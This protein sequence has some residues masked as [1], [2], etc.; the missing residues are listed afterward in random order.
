MNQAAL[1]KRTRRQSTRRALR[2][3]GR[4]YELY[5]FLLPALIYYIVFH[6]WPMYGVQ[7][8]FKDFI[9]IKGIEGSPWVGLK[10]FIRFVN[11]PSFWN[12]IRNTLGISLYSLA[13]GFPIPI[14][15]ALVLNELRYPRF[16]RLVQ[17]VSYAP[18]FISTVV[19]VSMLTIFLNKNY[20]I[21]NQLAGALGAER[22]A[23]MERPEWFKTIYVLSGV[24]QGM[25]WS[26][27]IYL[28]ALSGIDLSLHEAAMIDGAG[29]LRRI[30]HINLPGILP[31]VTILFIM[32]TGNLMSVGFEK[33]YL[34]Q[35]DLT[36]ETSEVISTYVYKVGLLQ[37]QYSFSA[38]VG[39][40][41]SVI[42]FVLLAV[43][44]GICGRLS[45]TSLW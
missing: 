16:K 9:A 30:W 7:I 20:G 3:M 40:F 32:Q 19:M 28:S 41:T 27:I 31:T 13:A 37:V 36:L 4:D 42:N 10:H 23:Y 1:S 44:N 6:F 2:R 29:R 5:L 26:S 24:W 33:I 8:A 18:H 45:E 38:A 43:V 15:L 21:V 11:A 34:M 22:V 17:T 39:L 14:L 35:N 12:L 25:G